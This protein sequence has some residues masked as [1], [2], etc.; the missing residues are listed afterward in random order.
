MWQSVFKL[1]IVIQTIRISIPYILAAIGGTFSERGGVVNIGLEGIIL[2]GAFCAVLVTWYTGNAWLGVIAAVLGG[3]L[4]ALIHAVV[5][6][7]YKADQIISGVAIN[8]FAVGITKFILQIVF[9][10]SSNSARVAG[11]PFWKIPFI[12]GIPILDTIFSTPLILL[13]LFIVVISHIVL[14]KTSFGLRLRSCGEHPQAADTLGVK[15]NL[16]RYAGVLVSGALAGLAGAWLS[17]DQ[18]QF[19]DGMSGGRGFIAL[20]AMIFGKWTPFGATG[21]ALLF[22]FAEALQI[23]LQNAG[24]KIPT[25][26]I[27]MI[28]YI[29][30]IIVLINAIGRAIPPAASGKPYEP[31]ED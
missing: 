26:F 13:T 3:M 8:L 23:Q 27:Q 22:G 20:A 25:Q 18:H 11:L 21:A 24:V 16:M 28:P 29:V 31:S 9:D 17:L 5:S 1:V 7:R 6:I 30:T 19:T 4:T 12:G 10:S 15:V 14:F 2:N